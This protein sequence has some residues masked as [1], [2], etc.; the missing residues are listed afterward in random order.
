MNPASHER[1]PA[2]LATAELAGFRRQ[3][4]G[5][6]PSGLSAAIMQKYDR[7]K[8]SSMNPGSH[9]PLFGFGKIR[10]TAWC[11]A[12]ICDARYFTPASPSNLRTP[13]SAR[14]FSGGC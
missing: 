1:Q 9:K 12:W 5:S 6:F 3:P 11:S 7:R 4:A 14:N 13:S 10:W 8:W 2:P